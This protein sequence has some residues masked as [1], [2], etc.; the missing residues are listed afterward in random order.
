MVCFG[1]CSVIVVI[2]ARERSLIIFHPGSCHH[3]HPKE[4]YSA[5][6]WHHA[7]TPSEQNSSSGSFSTAVADQ[8]SPFHLPSGSEGMCGSGSSGGRGYEVR[9]MRAGEVLARSDVLPRGEH[10]ARL[11]I[12]A[13]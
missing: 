10:C 3:H 5:T 13:M 7:L 12:C 1:T 8:G 6:L 11:Y 9:Y 2:S 4:D